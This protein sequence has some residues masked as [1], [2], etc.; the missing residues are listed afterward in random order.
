M[1]IYSV[2]WV[3]RGRG[4]YIP[5]DPVCGGDFYADE[6]GTDI[7]TATSAKIAKAAV[8]MVRPNAKVKRPCVISDA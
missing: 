7:I 2:S 3:E 8:E 1:K 5:P 6:Q 4:Q